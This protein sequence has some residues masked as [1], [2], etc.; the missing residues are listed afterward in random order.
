MKLSIGTGIFEIM[1]FRTGFDWYRIKFLESTEI[2]KR[3]LS[4]AHNREI[5]SDLA[6]EI[7]ACLQQGRSFFDI[8]EVSPLEI[9]PLLL[10]YGMVGFGRALSI[11]KSLSREATLPHAHGLKDCS[12]PLS[13]LEDHKLKFHKSGTFQVMNDNSN[14]LEKAFLHIGHQTNFVK[15]SKCDSKELEGKI[16]KLK[17]I[18]ARTLNM[19]KL[20][21]DTFKEHP[22]VF[23]C[24]HFSKDFWGP[25]LSFQIYYFPIEKERTV[26][27]EHVQVLRTKFAFLNSWK[28]HSAS[29][30]GPEPTFTF[31]AGPPYGFDEFSEEFLKEEAHRFEAIDHG[32]SDDSQTELPDDLNP[33]SGSLHASTCLIEPFE[34]LQLSELSLYYL[35]MFILSSIVR[36]RPSIWSNAISG[37]SGPRG[38]V[39]DK[40][41]AMVEKFLALSETRFPTMI[42]QAFENI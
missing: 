4:K 37:R 23:N 33:I 11:S 17:E 7:K 42:E 12:E 26:L 27:K 1:V 10:F 29:W 5:S 2:L 39:D 28:L 32:E 19:E 34:G 16:I 20:F 25:G 8:A 41:L 30:A 18:W 9:K 40:C 24:S 13:L 15:I 22:K 31:V 14:S 3:L 38:T 35:G 36:Y 21:E 6:N